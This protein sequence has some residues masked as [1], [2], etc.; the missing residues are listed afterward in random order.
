MSE[1]GVI[2]GTEY[3]CFSVGDLGVVQ[4]SDGWAGLGAVIEFGAQRLEFGVRLWR[5]YGVRRWA[6]RGWV[7]VDAAEGL[8]PGGG[9]AGEV[10]GVAVGAFGVCVGGVMSAE[11]SLLV[12]E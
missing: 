11:E 6:C 7:F 3:R 12:A 2:A 9:V 5:D 1:S 4:V 8:G 10:D